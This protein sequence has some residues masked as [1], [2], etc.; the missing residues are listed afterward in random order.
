MG[1]PLDLV[2]GPEAGGIIN[3]PAI[4]IIVV[5]A[6]LLIAGTRESATLNA[7]LVVVKL[8]ALGDVHRG[9]AAGVQRRQFRRRS[10]PTVSRA[11]DR[12]GA[13]SG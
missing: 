2:Q 10:C 8:A 7:M 4:F 11:A 6:G 13:K 1:L 5:V 12:R 9:R 3:L